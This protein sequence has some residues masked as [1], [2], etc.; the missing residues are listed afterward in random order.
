MLWSYENI[1]DET[2]IGS[3]IYQ[4]PA[5]AVEHSKNYRTTVNQSIYRETF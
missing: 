3:L 2:A 4:S 1:L 5:S